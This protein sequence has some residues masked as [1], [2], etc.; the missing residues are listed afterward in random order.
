MRFFANLSVLA[1]LTS[2][3]NSHTADGYRTATPTQGSGCPVI[4]PGPATA[5]QLAELP[6]S[7]FPDPRVT[8]SIRNILALYAFS[9]DSRNWAGFATV[10]AVDARANYSEPLGVVVG[11]ENITTAISAGLT[12]FAGTQHRYAT[13]YIG[14]CSPSSAISITYFEAS[15]FF[16]SAIA[17]AVQNTTQT[18]YAVGRYEDTWN[19]QD[20]ET[21]KITN[22]NL[23]YMVSKILAL[24]WWSTE[25]TLSQGPLMLDAA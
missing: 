10:F 19:K 20:D 18:L 6:I 4:S 3:A 9:V 11:V 5:S 14:I 15:H 2:I 8:E 22:R 23:V 24:S 21:W 13:Q 12:G 25:L 17:P 16:S 1:G 7:P